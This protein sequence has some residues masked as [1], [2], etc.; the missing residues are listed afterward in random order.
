M[1]KTP[2]RREDDQP[3]AQQ[4]RHDLVEGDADGSPAR[5]VN[6]RPRTTPAIAVTAAWVAG[7][8]QVAA[9]A[10]RLPILPKPS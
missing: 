8:D 10:D 9:E 6:V 7:V 4:R 1:A 2:P 5:T 3:P